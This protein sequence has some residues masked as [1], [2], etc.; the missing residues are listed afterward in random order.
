MESPG[1][2][3]FD[4]LAYQR[5][6]YEQLEARM[7]R[8]RLHLRLALNPDGAIQA[9]RDMQA[10]QRHYKSM[11]A[12]A[13][14]RHDRQTSQD[15]YAGEKSYYDQI[16]AKVDQQMQQFYTAL[17]G[18][19]H[20]QALEIALGSLIFRKAEN[21]R[22]TVKPEAV[23]DLA[24]ENQLVSEYEQLMSAIVVHLDGR[25]L[26]AAQLDP[27]L[28]S[29][30]RDVRRR[31]HEALAAALQEQAEPLDRL[32]DELVQVRH[33]ISHKLG[34]THFTEL[35][36][37]RMERFD[38]GREQVEDL[39]RNILRYI[40]PLTREIRRL[41]RR[42]LKL[43]HL[44]Y[45]DL[46][47]LFPDGNPPLLPGADG[48]ADATGRVLAKLTGQSPSFLQ[49]LLDGGYLDLPARPDKAQGGY[50]ETIHTAGAPFILM[51]AGGTAQDA[52]VLL[53]EAGHAY[54]S[55]SS[56][57]NADW[58]EYH[59]PTLETCEIHSTT[60]EYLAYPHMAAFFGPA[61]QDYTLMHLTET[62][63]FLPYGCMVDEFQH[64]IYDE[65]GLTAAQRNQV[66]SALEKQYQPDLDYGGAPFFAAGRAWQ[67]KEH[68][69]VAPFY[70]IDYVLAQLAAL[71]LW[72]VAGKEP[73]KAWRQYER[74][75]SLGGHGTFLELLG[76]SD[77]DSPFD[78]DVI[79]RLAYTVCSYLS[80]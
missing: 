20:R 29:A 49:P 10:I 69:Y 39:R 16:E 23:K 63:L 61:A 54:A 40:V 53:H 33:G 68:I 58:L 70:Y 74:L 32:F 51:N 37:R 18:S 45:Y 8:A 57:K 43:D 31:A 66:W 56:L 3:P 34:F 26:S 65:P 52:S 50:C 76:Q 71:E 2:V 35:G 78:P 12:L 22:S 19:R 24:R 64:R 80:L 11:S 21:F 79:K 7:R 9:V 77:L 1:L 46:P 27:D 38:Y 47:C 73:A 75:C 48:L 55:L 25:S 28:Q 41:Q 5:V 17:L 72:Q 36:Y 42:R 60:L 59:Q 14:I 44:F 4:A 62:L 67:R 30:E 6:D 13:H 15:F